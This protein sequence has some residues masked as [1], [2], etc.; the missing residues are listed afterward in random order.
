MSKSKEEAIVE[1]VNALAENS[2]VPFEAYA[3]P[4]GGVMV[5]VF[6]PAP[7]GNRA[8]DMIFNSDANPDW[9]LAIVKAAVGNFEALNVG[10]GKL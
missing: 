6:S 3:K 8:F 1:A 5:N 7:I 10:A 4:S 2:P 9:V